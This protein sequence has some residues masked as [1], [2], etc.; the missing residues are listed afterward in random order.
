MVKE[1][2]LREIGYHPDIRTDTD[3]LSNIILDHLTRAIDLSTHQAAV[4]R[5]LRKRLAEHQAF[6]TAGL[7]TFN[8]HIDAMLEALGY[9][10]AEKNLTSEDLSSVF[11]KTLR[12]WPEFMP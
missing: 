4:A 9:E 3:E 10:P 8:D 5:A 11:G 12:Q 6:E 2:F 7:Q 1:A